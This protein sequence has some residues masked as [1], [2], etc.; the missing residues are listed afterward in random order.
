MCFVKSV[1]ASL[2]LMSAEESEWLTLGHTAEQTK[3][4]L[5]KITREDLMSACLRTYVYRGEGSWLVWWLE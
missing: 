4:P 2:S 3:G 1:I 5:E